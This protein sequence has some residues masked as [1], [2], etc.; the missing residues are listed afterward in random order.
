MDTCAK[1]FPSLS[2][3][4]NSK[5]LSSIHKTRSLYNPS[6]LDNPSGTPALKKILQHINQQSFNTIKACNG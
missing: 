3:F 5:F 4:K 1:Y 6:L 2:A